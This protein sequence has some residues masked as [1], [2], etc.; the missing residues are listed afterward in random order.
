MEI[1]EYL[2]LKLDIKRKHKRTLALV[3]QAGAWERVLQSRVPIFISPIPIFL[4]PNSHIPN[5]PPPIINIDSLYRIWNDFL[6]A[7]RY[8]EWR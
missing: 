8:F 5:S 1:R 2:M 3:D 6:H 4:I 7:V